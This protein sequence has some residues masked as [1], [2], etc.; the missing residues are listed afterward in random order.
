MGKRGLFALAVAAT[1]LAARA[2]QDAGQETAAEE[3]DAR[4]ET[5]AEERRD[6]ESAAAAG[7][8]TSDLF[9]RACVDLLQGRTPEGEKA[10]A[11]LKDA[12]ADLMS[13]KADEKIQQRE[14]QQARALGAQ[15]P[16]GEA[17]RPQGE[18]QGSRGAGAVQEGEG[19]RASFERAARELT[20][21]GRAQMMGFRQRG[22]VGSTLV[23][24]PIGWFNGLGMNAE[25][26]RSFEPKLSWVAGARYSTTDATNGT[27]TTFG[28]MAGVDW[29]VLGRNNEGLRIGPR[30]ELAAGR[31]E[32]QGD[33]TFAR[34][35]LGGEIGYNFIATNGLTAL[36]AGGMGGRFAGDDENEDFASFV[37]G[38]FGPYLKMGL[39]YSW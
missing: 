13:A 18:A 33:T 21:P 29:F 7:G 6:A 5:A 12:C 36:L 1:A 9:E 24:N 23:T 3:Q 30:L 34:A 15:P 32:F 26:Y 19:V 20:G 25:L 11:T 37:G 4:R 38:E 28:A 35:G 27:A 17:E 16:Q 31:E 2:Q 22:P 10:I 8:A 39:G 14:L